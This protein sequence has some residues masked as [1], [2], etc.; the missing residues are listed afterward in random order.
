MADVEGGAGLHD[1]AIASK[2]RRQELAEL[3]VRHLVALDGEP[4]L[5]VSFVV[6]VVGRVRKDKVGG[7]T[8]HELGDIGFV[9]GVAYQ[10]REVQVATDPRQR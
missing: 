3:L 7:M 10:Q 6:H 9:G 2:G 5:G 8:V 1:P 4:V